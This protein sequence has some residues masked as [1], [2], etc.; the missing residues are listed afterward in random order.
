MEIRNKNG[1]TIFEMD[2]I[3]II[4]IAGIIAFYIVGHC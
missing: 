3:N 4:I 1:K 2:D